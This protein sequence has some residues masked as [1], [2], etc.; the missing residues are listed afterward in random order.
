MTFGLVSPPSDLESGPD[1][2]GSGPEV[3]DG[4][5]IQRI[6]ETPAGSFH[7]RDALH[8][9]TIVLYEGA[10]PDVCELATHPV[11]GRGRGNLHWTVKAR[12]DGS[13]SIQATFGGILELTAGG[14]A[15]LLGVGHVVFD[16]FGNVTIHTD[17]FRVKPIGK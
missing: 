1:C 8:Q 10:T 16:Q 13:T 11:V 5:G 6:V 3:Y 4:G 14:R 17:H 12:V 15:Q 9:A 2:G 7:V